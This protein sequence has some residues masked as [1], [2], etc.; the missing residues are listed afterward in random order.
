MTLG[1]EERLSVSAYLLKNSKTAEAQQQLEAASAAVYPLID[2]IPGGAFIALPA[3]T[4]APRGCDQ[5]QC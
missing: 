5:S 3:D 4:E 2:D 1:E